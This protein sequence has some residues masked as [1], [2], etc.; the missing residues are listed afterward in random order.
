[1]SPKYISCWWI[2]SGLHFNRN[3]VRF[4]CYEYLHSNN[5]NIIFNNYKGQKLDYS[6]YFE[7]KNLYK[8]RAKENNLPVNCQ[9]CIYLEEK[10]W[11]EENY[12][13]HFIFNHWL[14]CNSNCIYC[15][16]RYLPKNQQIQYY[17]IYPV[18]KD[19]KSNGLLKNTKTS[20]V[21]FG[22]GEPLLL[23][24]FEKLMKFFITEGFHNIRINSSGIKYSKALENA[25]KENAASLVISPD[26]G[27]RNMYMKIK[28]VDCFD[29]VWNN[30]KLYS[31]YANNNSVKV[32]YIV[33]P[34]I[35]D[36][37]EEIDKFFNM[38]QKSNINSISVS[39]EQNWYH[40]NYPN[41]PDNIFLI[42]D[43]FIEKAKHYNFDIELYCEAISMLKC[44][45]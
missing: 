7:I 21:V 30:I 3:Q 13:D 18:L 37:K 33:I 11:D 41:F 40:R 24:E 27:S 6:K 22:G 31:K 26:C 32:K 10:E 35:N 42:F 16:Q 14:N 5:D 43:Y 45:K 29:T 25:L 44:R 34:K 17:D 12:I 2:N 19:I 1:M 23:K 38:V 28:Q 15:G 39:I 9:N 20:C 8:K 4:C 36:T